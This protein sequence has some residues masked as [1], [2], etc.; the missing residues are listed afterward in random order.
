MNSKPSFVQ[1]V[2][3]LEGRLS[4]AE[5]EQIAAEVAADE[6]L[7]ADSEWLR[8]FLQ[9][10]DDLAWDAPPADVRA[11]LSRRFAAFAAEN[12]PTAL[13][14]RL[15]ATLKFDSQMQPATW[16]VR[17][18]SAN[19]ERQLVYGTSYADVALTIQSVTPAK[20]C[21]LF[22]Q[23]LPTTAEME[24]ISSIQLLQKGEER[25]FAVAAEVGEFVFEEMPE[26]EYE[27]AILTDRYEIVIPLQLA[28]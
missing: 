3:W 10:R 14:Q 28:V 13:W 27:L 11:E 6:T 21:N 26:G 8:T 1:L 2:D 20:L 5:S 7:Q 12:R 22:G 24:S 23:I 18:S 17:T 9:T 16:G 19:R 25:A 4:T 15:T